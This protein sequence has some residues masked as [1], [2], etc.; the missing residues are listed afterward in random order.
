MPLLI[1]TLLDVNAAGS[2]NMMSIMTVAVTMVIIIIIVVK[3][4]MV[5]VVSSIMKNPSNELISLKAQN[6]G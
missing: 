5:K 3:K 6:P 4:I 2:A 1:R